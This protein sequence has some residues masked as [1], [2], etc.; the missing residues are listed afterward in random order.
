MHKMDELQNFISIKNL[1]LSVCNPIRYANEALDQ[2]YLKNFSRYFDENNN[3]LTKEIIIKTNLGDEKTLRIPIVSLVNPNQIKLGKMNVNI[4][5]YI[6]GVDTDGELILAFRK[7]PDIGSCEKIN[8]NFT[9]NSKIPSEIMV[10]IS[11]GVRV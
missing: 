7:T 8:I 9:I 5:A 4:S 6:V 1:I 2:D 10:E 11:K 3:P